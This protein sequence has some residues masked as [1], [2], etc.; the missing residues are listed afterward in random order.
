[1]ECTFP[2]LKE[3][4]ARLVGSARCGIEH[5]QETAKEMSHITPQNWNVSIMMPLV[6]GYL[7]T[8]KRTKS[9]LPATAKKLQ[10]VTLS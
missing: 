9:T 5:E 3:H 4:K 8:Q 6:Q 10:K 2:K 1:M 7:V